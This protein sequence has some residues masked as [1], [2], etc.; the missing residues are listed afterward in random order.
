MGLDAVII[1]AGLY[2]QRS[3]DQERKERLQDFFR[4]KNKVDLFEAEEIPNDEQINE[5]IARSEEEF[6]AFIEADKI[7]YEQEKLLYKNFIEYKD[8]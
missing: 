1:Q 5:W 2:N 3:T 6:E 7:R 8:D 4:S